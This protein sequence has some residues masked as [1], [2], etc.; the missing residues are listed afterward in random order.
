M[1]HP[2]ETKE[3]AFSLRETGY[4]VK[5]IAKQLSISQSTASI[6]VRN[7]E[8]NTPAQ[9]RLKNR[10]ELGYYKSAL[11]WKIK[12]EVDE[13]KR[14]VDTKKILGYTRKGTNDLKIYCTL[15]YCC[16]GGKS[17]TDP[18]KFVNSDPILMRAFLYTLRHGFSIDEGK[19]RVLMHLHAYHDEKKQKEFWSKI[20]G[21]PKS[22]FHK[23]FQK[24]NTGKRIKE[25]YAGCVSVSYYDRQLA[26]QIRTLGKN[27]LAKLGA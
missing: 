27:L 25:N 24:P 19:F 13:A 14:I 22:Q 9:K 11:R 21:I 20:T 12:R 10:K 5:E 8:L 7:I 15:L 2:I 26:R 16:E 4:S 23:T 1:P 3:K 18:I 6:W 17:D